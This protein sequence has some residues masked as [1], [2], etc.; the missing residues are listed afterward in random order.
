MKLLGSRLSVCWLVLALLATLAMVACG[1]GGGKASPTP[2]P[3]PGSMA[4]SWDF[5][6]IAGKTPHPVALEANLT[7]DSSGNISAMGS[8]TA[9]GPAG[10]V[11]EADTVGSSLATT[12]DISVDY[13]GFTCTGSDSGDRSITGTINSSNQVTLALDIGGT[14]VD[15]IT[16]TLNTSAN[17]PFSGTMSTS[18]ICGGPGSVSVTGAPASFPP[19]GAYGGTTA[20]DNTV[21]ISVGITDTNGTL[22]GLGGETNLGNFTVAGNT[23]GNA[24]SAT[25]TYSTSPSSSGPVF[26]YFDPQLGAKGSILLI[27]FKGGNT[28]TC[29][30]GVGSDAGSCLIAILALQ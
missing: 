30:P 14:E 22:T 20:F 18:G 10:N 27:S 9:S 6:V 7:Q 5:T 2:T 15:T 25:L 26:G 21:N 24:F 28:A 3:K 1:G 8:V 16:G 13:L 4:G 19:M 23:V 12:T 17:P 11:L 29:S